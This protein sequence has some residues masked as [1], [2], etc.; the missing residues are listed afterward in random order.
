[1]AKNNGLIV[2]VSGLL[3]GAAGFFIYRSFKSKK[4]T[5]RLLDEQEKQKLDE[6]KKAKGEN[7]V[8]G[9]ADTIK[10]NLFKGLGLGEKVQTQEVKQ[11]EA[12]KNLN[13]TSV[14]YSKVGTRLREKPNSSSTIVATIQKAKV[15][16]NKLPFIGGG[17]FG[18][19]GV[20]ATPITEGKNIWF[21]VQQEGTDNKGWVR[22]DVVTL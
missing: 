11:V 13:S 9:I 3:V 1:M 12:T 14:L 19:S 21:Y 4:E 22:S 5:Q 16:L 2:V 7:V 17:M 6:D 18:L 15:K 8:K 10:T 20:P